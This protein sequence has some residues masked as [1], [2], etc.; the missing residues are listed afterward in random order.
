M[1]WTPGDTV[2]RGKR[3]NVTVVTVSPGRQRAALDRRSIVCAAG[4]TDT[5]T[6]SGEM[7]QG[8]RY[9]KG[10]F[11]RVLRERVNQRLAEEGRTFRGGARAWLTCAPAVVWF[12]GS[13]VALLVVPTHPVLIV[14]LTVSL[15]LA[16][17]ACLTVVQHDALHQAISRR[18]WVNWAAAYVGAPAGVSWRW[19]TAKH[20]GGH[21]AYTNVEG[22]DGDLTQ[23]ALIRLTPNQRWRPIH[24]YQHR[25]VWGLYALLAVSIQF[26]GDREFIVHGR[27]KGHPVAASSAR[28]TAVLAFE[29]LVGLALLLTIAALVHPSAWL[30][31]AYVLWWGVTGFTLAAVFGVTHY[32]DTSQFPQ[33]DASGMVADEWAVTQVVGSTNIRIRNRVIR[34]YF[35][36]VANHIEHHLFPRMS[37]VHYPLIAPVVRATCKEFGVPYHEAPSLG[38]VYG[39]HVRFLEQLGRPEAALVPALAAA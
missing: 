30:L 9:G 2:K 37:H 36:G 3:G 12:Y 1:T 8:I 26:T 32:V 18:R 22:H 17:T 31:P 21:H 10:E 34:W 19:W 20:S 11:H 23:S 14:T 24:R 4:D 15:G 25:Y 29:K 27:L 28:R 38:A 35:G 5:N 33:P 6:G 16:T 39:S 13:F 7:R